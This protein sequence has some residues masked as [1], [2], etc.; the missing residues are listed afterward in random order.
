MSVLL[1]LCTMKNDVTII[2][3]K[4]TKATGC[5][6][7]FWD[8]NCNSENWAGVKALITQPHKKKCQNPRSRPCTPYVFG[9]AESKSGVDLVPSPQDQRHFKVK[10]KKLRATMF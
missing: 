1:Y 5:K 6:K 3:W 9:V 7:V 8:L 4:K 10:S 2:I